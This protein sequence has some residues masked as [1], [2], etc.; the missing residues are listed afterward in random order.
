MDVT[1]PPPFA[2]GVARPTAVPLSG[3]RL[4]VGRDDVL[5]VPEPLDPEP[6]DPVLPLSFGTA[7]GADTGRPA[8]E[9]L[10]GAGLDDP[11]PPDG[12]RELVGR[13]PPCRPDAETGGAR[14]QLAVATTARMLTARFIRPIFV[15]P[16]MHRATQL[17]AIGA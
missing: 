6:L 1:P 9:P 17:P 11:P 5:P 13:P 8:L 12:G 16:W 14:S 10:P 7:R 4:D 15:L 2:G 3:V